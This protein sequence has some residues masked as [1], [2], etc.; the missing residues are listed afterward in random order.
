MSNLGRSLQPA[1]SIEKRLDPGQAWRHIGQ[2]RDS[3][4]QIYMHSLL[5]PGFV[6]TSSP[7]GAGSRCAEGPCCKQLT[8]HSFSKNQKTNFPVDAKHKSFH[9][10]PLCHPMLCPIIFV[11]FFCPVSSLAFGMQLEKSDLK[12]KSQERPGG[13]FLLVTVPLLCANASSTLIGCKNRLL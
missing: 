11:M 5:Q 10:D 3:C 1:C 13:Y 9:A 2:M 6:K 4:V 8:I 7:C 12:Y